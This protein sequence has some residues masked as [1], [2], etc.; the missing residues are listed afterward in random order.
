MAATE[1][2]NDDVAGMLRDSLRGFLDEHWR[3]RGA[4]A[5]S[6][7]DEVSAIWRKLVGQGVAALGVEGEGGLAEIFVVMAELGR[8]G[9]PAPMWSAALANLAISGSQVDVVVDLLERLHSGK[10]IVAF[11][12]GALD[13]DSG[14]GLIEVTDLKATGVL[15]FVEAAGGATHLLVVLDQVHLALI[16]LGGPG[17][18]CV[19]TRAMGAWGLH[20][21][22][23]NAAPLTCISVR[24][25]DLDHLRIRG[26]A[27][28]TARAYGAAQRAFELAVDYARE[29]HQFGQPIGKF[30]AIQHKLT[31]CLIA[32]EGVRLILEHTARLHDGGD[33]DWRYFADCA[34]AFSGNAL[35]QVSLET[36]HT[37]GAIGYAEE[38]EAPIHFKR[39]HLDAIALGGASDAKRRLAGRLLDAG[40][41]GLPQYDLG[42]AGNAFREQ[43]RRWLDQN[44]AGDS[45]QAFD[46]RPF[47]EREF[48]ANFARNIGETGWIGLGW[49]EQFGG[50]AR[51][52]LEQIAFMETME[53]GEAPRIGAAIQAN[54]LMMFGTP[55]QQQKY[56]PEI[57][58]G[59]AMHG[60][61]YSEPQAGSDLAALRTSAI[62]DGEHWVINGQKIW[63]T[64][65]WGK[66]MFLAARTDKDARPPHA[67]IS[68]FIVPMDAPG[69]TIRPSVTM[70]DGTFANIF[71][72]NVR[73]PAE[74]LVGEV[75]GGW[76]VLTGA[77]AFERGLVG[78][79][80]VLKVAHA[81][82]QLR[83]HVMDREGDLCLAEDPIVRDR[84][85]TL[86][87]EIEIGRQLMMHCAELA[88]D[89]VTPPEYGAISK[90]FSGELMERFGEAALDILG[91]R[92]AL[93][94]QMPG[95][96][97]NG[98]FE[99]NQRHSLMWVISIGT[100]EIQRSLI[101]QRALGLPR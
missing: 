38:H 29:R 91:M 81:F 25:D 87:S 60:M 20:E 12:F 9:C 58:R 97:D 48:D 43:V 5:S 94:E 73:I 78:G 66:Y 2:S 50:Q 10:A 52:P 22:R 44:W 93:S 68:M 51:S 99:Q 13:R 96:I 26:K 92:A 83:A 85:A 18:E 69:I 33:D 11:S 90:V 27:A 63:T 21:V 7:P 1:A 80:I 76:K 34:S 3:P 59:E 101:A 17:V 23:L 79:G 75:N 100:N 14:A 84:M 4:T 15:R 62:R 8:A 30:Q 70:Y 19:A 49:P 86:A 40:G 41:A 71:Y 53:R 57:L 6:S 67:G 24:T 55:E 89:G 64:T 82:E 77:L 32:L 88:A 47:A 95:A 54:A 61:G 98:R 74:N 45:K 31:N 35:R 72:D 56:L 28:L 42:S 37:F 65:W 16:D 39:V 36:Q 46:Q